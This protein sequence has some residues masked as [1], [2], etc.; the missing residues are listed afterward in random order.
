[1]YFEVPPHLWPALEAQ[2]W[3]SADC[4]AGRPPLLAYC[5]AGRPHALQLDIDKCPLPLG[6]TGH[7]VS[8]PTL[9]EGPPQPETETE[10]PNDPK[11]IPK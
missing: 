4:A 1:M 9:W 11:L 2:L 10:T 5:Y 8:P 3:A 6:E 7:A